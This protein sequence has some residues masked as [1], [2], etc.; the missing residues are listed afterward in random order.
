[1]KHLAI[2]GAGTGGTIVVADAPLTVDV[3]IVPSAER[4]NSVGECPG[5]TLQ[6]EK[7]LRERGR[8]LPTAHVIEVV[9]ASISGR[10]LQQLRR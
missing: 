2:L 6:I 9:D 8:S 5:C 7:M 1:M 10:V 4:P 3:H